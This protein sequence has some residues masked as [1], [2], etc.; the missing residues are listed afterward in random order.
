[1]AEKRRQEKRLWFGNAEYEVGLKYELVRFR[2]RT[3]IF[4]K[5]AIFQE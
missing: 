2:K 1:M 4:V 3:M 5:V